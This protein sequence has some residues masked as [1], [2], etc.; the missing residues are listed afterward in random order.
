MPI[1]NK[2]VDNFMAKVYGNDYLALAKELEPLRAAGKRIVM[3]SGTFDLFHIGH[4]RMLKAAKSKG[5][6]LVVAVKS[7]KAA[8]LKKEDPPV[9]NQDY[10]MEAVSNC[11]Y[12]DYVILAEY[13]IYKKMPDFEF[14]NTSSYEWLTIFNPVVE[15]IRPDVFVHE[16][17]LTIE[18][19]RKQ[20]FEYYNVSGIIQPRTEGISTTELIDKIKTRILKKMQENNEN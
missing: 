3:C 6:I 9:I 1:N 14:Y 19:A 13:D 5:D 10:R 11:I 16:D 7:D 12:P 18:Y 17:N 20:L 2:E 4:M 8:S 15:T